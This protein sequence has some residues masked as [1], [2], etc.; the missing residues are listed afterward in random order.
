VTKEEMYAKLEFRK[1]TAKGLPKGVKLQLDAWHGSPYQFAKFMLENID[2]GEGAQA[3]GWGLYFTDLQDV[4]EWYANELGGVKDNISLEEIKN[5]LPSSPN[6]ESL[7]I[8]F[9]RNIRIRGVREGLQKFKENTELLG[10]EFYT[11]EELN[12]VKN[13][14]EKDLPAKFVY[15]VNLFKNKKRYV[16][17]PIQSLDGKWNVYDSKTW[18]KVQQ[19]SSAEKQGIL[20]DLDRAKPEKRFNSKEEA[21]SWINDNNEYTFLEW[22]KPLNKERAN[23]LLSKLTKDQNEQGFYYGLSGVQTEGEFYK[24]LT[25]AFG[26]RLRGGDKAASLFLLENGIDGIKYPAESIAA[27]RTSDNARGFNYV[28]FDENAINI[29]DVIKFQKDANKARGAVMVGMDG[30]AVIYALTNPNVSTPLHEL[31]HVYEHYLTDAEKDTVLKSAGTKEWTTETS[32]YFARG[33]EKYIAEGK[34]PSESLSNVFEKFKQWLKDIY[35]DLKNS[36]IDV[37]LN[38]GMRKIY[39]QMLGAQQA[40][41]ETKV[42]TKTEVKAETPS[43]KA[44]P[45]FAEFDAISADRGKMKEAKAA[46]IEKHGQLAYDAMKEISTNFTKISKALQEKEILTKKC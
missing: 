8:N 20:D 25:N 35:K 9:E 38:D 1:A 17:A 14:Q 12:F 24:K 5:I 29:E 21:L 6:V 23:K 43:T 15:K 7:A 32:E 34:S 27:G 10:L 44:L 26:G 22:D 11:P 42:E 39:A 13:L 45:S 31:A 46:F 18:D 40:K 28:I 16:A 33:F 30:Q 37:K 36:P 2:T 19:M 41:T 3:F 4:A